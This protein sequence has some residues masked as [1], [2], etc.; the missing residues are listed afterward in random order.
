MREFQRWQ[1]TPL[2]A[3]CYWQPATSRRRMADLQSRSLAAVRLTLPGQM[4]PRHGRTLFS[5]RLSSKRP[6]IKRVLRDQ[7][8]PVFRGAVR[9][10]WGGLR[11]RSMTT[12]QSC[13]RK[14]RALPLN[15]R[16]PIDTCSGRKAPLWQRHSNSLRSA[17][18]DRIGSI[19]MLART[20]LSMSTSRSRKLSREE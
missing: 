1:S 17:M 4:W 6:T 19:Q 7:V 13:Y 11:Y 20:V 16:G 14:L 2:P 8:Q 18:S 9:R 5:G 3:T 12:S 15:S 10:D